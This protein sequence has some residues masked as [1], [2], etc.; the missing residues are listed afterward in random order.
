MTDLVDSN[1][2]VT[3][4]SCGMYHNAVLTGAIMS[5]HIYIVKLGLGLGFGLGRVRARVK[6]RVS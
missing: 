4:I 1:V 6:V 5:Q 3:D 2:L